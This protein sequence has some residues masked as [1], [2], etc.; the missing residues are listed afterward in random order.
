MTCTKPNRRCQTI[1]PIFI[2]MQLTQICLL[3][4]AAAANAATPNPFYNVPTCAVSSSID[5][6][7][8]DRAKFCQQNCAKTLPSNCNGNPKCICQNQSWM[9]NVECCVSNQCSSSDQVSTFQF[10][11]Q[12]CSYVNVKITAPPSCTAVRNQPTSTLKTTTKP[13]PTG[14]PANVNGYASK[15]CYGEATNGGGNRALNKSDYI[16]PTGMT[17][18]S[19]VAYCK[20]KSLSFAGLEYSQEWVISLLLIPGI[21]LMGT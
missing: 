12:L 2:S 18:E 19:C 4:F 13:V 21:M 15:G 1:G 10:A 20:S 5:L 16:D 6:L 14:N 9:W 7:P 8:R 11:N 3:G 17:V